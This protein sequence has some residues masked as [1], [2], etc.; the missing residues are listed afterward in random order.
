MPH[1]V[2]PPTVLEARPL[3][4]YVRRDLIDLLIRNGTSTHSRWHETL[5]YMIDFCERC[6][7]S[8]TLT[9]ISK[10]SL[11]SYELKAD[12][13]AIRRVT[14]VWATVK[15]SKYTDKPY[16]RLTLKDPSGS[17]T[18]FTC[19]ITGAG[20]PRLNRLLQ[21]LDI[22]PY[23]GHALLKNF[24]RKTFYVKM[25]TGTFGGET[26]RRPVPLFR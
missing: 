15:L 24:L 11:S 18:H 16:L 7:V 20:V 13:A 21:V 5:A 23:S 6:G 12:L 1:K 3:M 9:K 4:D 17:K 19:G 8:Y 25:E 2:N 14:V 22:T 26:Y 10:G